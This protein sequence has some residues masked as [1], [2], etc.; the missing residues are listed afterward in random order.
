VPTREAHFSRMYLSLSS[1]CQQ[2]DAAH[3]HVQQHTPRLAT[4]TGIVSIAKVARPAL[5][6][7]HAIFSECTNGCSSGT[8]VSVGVLALNFVICTL[9]LVAVHGD[10]ST[11]NL[12]SGL[13][14]FLLCTSII[15][16]NWVAVLCI[17]VCYLMRTRNVR[18]TLYVVHTVQFICIARELLNNRLGTNSTYILSTHHRRECPLFV[19]CA[20]FLPFIAIDQNLYLQNCAVYLSMHLFCTYLFYFKSR[21]ISTLPLVYSLCNTISVLGAV[22]T[23]STVPDAYQ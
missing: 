12:F 5:F 23:R 2:S 19:I 21:G 18:R 20:I 16:L 11:V 3:T 15:T 6:T 10:T 13:F 7:L 14:L 1:K 8:V 22:C 9:C 17:V 4:N